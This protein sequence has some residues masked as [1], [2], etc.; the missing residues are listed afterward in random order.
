MNININRKSILVLTV[1]ILLCQAA[2]I[3]G[4]FIVSPESL[5]WYEY[6]FKPALTPTD[7]LFQGVWVI[8]YLLMGVSLYLVLQK[9]S[10]V[11]KKFALIIFG[12]QLLLNILLV[13]VFFGLKSTI[14]GLII[15]ILLWM[16]L[17]LMLYK[18]YKI[19]IPAALLIIPSVLWSAYLVGLNLTFWM[20]NSTHWV[21][22]SF[23]QNL[24]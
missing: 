23:K 3:I 18:F 8:L 7:W 9:D 17:C 21:F 13:P 20:L 12:S 10:P 4:K 6:L 22:W 11:S 19:T 2:G 1:S 24:H 5:I 16:S 14:G 15:S